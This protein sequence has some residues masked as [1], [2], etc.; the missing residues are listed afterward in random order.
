MPMRGQTHS[1]ACSLLV[2]QTNHNRSSSFTF[3][4]ERD[5]GKP[6]VRRGRKAMGLHQK[7]ARLP[8][9]LLAISLL[10]SG[11]QALGRAMRFGYLRDAL[12]LRPMTQR[13]R[14]RRAVA[15]VQVRRS[16]SQGDRA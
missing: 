6:V 7:I 12:A 15:S 10:A 3:A 13:R 16:K 5:N 4:G 8:N 9:A 2:G 11:T 1:L 14:V